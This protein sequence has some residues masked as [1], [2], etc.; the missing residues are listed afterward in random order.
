M[1]QLDSQRLQGA[2]TAVMDALSPLCATRE[3]CLQ[4]LMHVTA[5]LL[6]GQSPAYVVSYFAKINDILQGRFDR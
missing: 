4:V 1:N 3:E 5:A 2:V 6:E